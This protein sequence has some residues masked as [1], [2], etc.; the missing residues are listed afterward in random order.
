MRPGVPL[1]LLAFA[2]GG[3]GNGVRMDFDRGSLFDA[4]FPGPDLIDDRGVV[5]LEIDNA[6][7]VKFVDDVVGLLSGSATGFGTTSAIYFATTGALDPA[8]IPTVAG[9]I[10]PGSP[11]FLVA[12][13]PDRPGYLVPHPIEVSFR[14]DGGPF[15]PKNQLSLLPVQGLPL[16]PATRYAAVVMRDL[17]TASG[18]RLDQAGAVA[19]LAGGDAEFPELAAAAAAL[20][21]MGIDLADVAALT[22]FRTQDPLVGLTR[23]VEAARQL[24]TPAPITAWTQTDVF[25]GFCVYETRIEMPVYQTGTPPFSNSGG[26]WSD[27]PDV[28]TTEE[29]RLIATIPRAAAPAGG[30]P[31]AVMIRTGGGGD[32]PLVD[33]GP[34]D[35]SGDVIEPGSGPGMHF[36]EIGW[37]G[38][39]VDGPHGGIRNVTGGD[40]QFL[41]FN[42]RNPGAIRDNIRQSALELALLPDVIAGL[43]GAAAIDVSDCPGAAVSGATFDTGKLALMGHSMG[44]TIAPLVLAV[45]PRYGAAILSGAGGSWTEN[46]IHKQSPVPIL[47]VA[48]GLL[49]YTGTGLSLDEHDF[50]LNLFQ[51]ATEVSDPPS[52]GRAVIADADAPRHVLMFQ[53]IVDTYI[54]PPIANATTL[55][56]GLDLAGDAL[57]RDHPDLAAFDPIED[58][59]PLSGRA[60]IEYPASGNVVTHAGV[61]VTAVVV[62]HLEGPI[63]D[64]HEIMFEL[65]ATKAQYKAFLGSWQQGMPVVPAP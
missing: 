52:Y 51:W 4:P 33:R 56:L 45:E 65:D 5:Q 50:A 49:G 7:R 64:G 23:F 2:C 3:D 61:E 10:E 28:Q 18:G 21:E 48:E 36:A 53:G 40:E 31:T 44:A 59:L 55:S 43:G 37:A 6:N 46:V 9:S 60:A 8:G 11:V 30:Y 20:A 16:R 29:A 17:A 1:V 32:R 19:R 42:I 38:V 34:R 35:A 39:S 24:P 47:P 14:A 13:D 57:D 54:L 62:Q 41:I 27:E 63:E 26:T 15:G 25:D 58:M 22:A 12:I